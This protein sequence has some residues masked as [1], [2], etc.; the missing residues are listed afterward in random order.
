MQSLNSAGNTR[1]AL[2]V[3]GI[4]M[5]VAFLFLVPFT[6]F[7]AGSIAV[8]SPTAGAFVAAG[9][10]ITVSGTVSNGT[11]GSV[12]V[13][14]VAPNGQTVDANQFTVTGG[15]FTG[16][17]VTGGPSYTVNGT[18]TI[19][20]NYNG[21]TAS[22]QVTYGSNSTQTG[23]SGTGTTTTVIVTTETTV[24]VDSVTTVSAVGG[25]ATTTTVISNI[26][27]TTVTSVVNSI[28]TVVSSVAGSDST[29]EAYR[30]SRHNHCNHCNR[31]CRNGNASQKVIKQDQK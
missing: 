8:T 15:A 27:G 26:A 7:A 13:S 18:Y 21:A 5:F 6:A 23:G 16:T 25:V 29:A 31:T 30:S 24:T 22:V 4:G 1:K 14:I 20:L 28:T 2:T 11:T 9:S 10:T 19:N 3:T 12:A 17:F